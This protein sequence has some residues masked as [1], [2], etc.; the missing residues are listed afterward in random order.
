[1]GSKKHLCRV[2][3]LVGLQFA[4]WTE[5]AFSATITTFNDIQ[6]WVGTGEN[7]AA[8]VVDWDDSTATDESLIWGYRWTGTAT[9]SDMLQAVLAADDR[10][11]AKLDTSSTLAFG[12]GYDLNNDNQFAISDGSTFDAAGI[13]T[14]GPP[15]PP[16]APGT[17]SPSDTADHY[18][19][20][21]YTGFWNYGMSTGSASPFDDGAWSA[22]NLG[23]AGRVLT[24]GD[25]DSWAFTPDTDPP[26]A[27]FAENPYAAESPFSADFDADFDADDDI[28]GADF[29]TW[30]RGFGITAGASLAQGDANGD[31]RVDQHDLPIWAT[32]FGSGF[33]FGTFGS[34]IGSSA[35]QSTAFVV[36]EPS[37]IAAAVWFIVLI[38]NR[39]ISTK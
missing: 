21:W 26:H 14:G 36:P 29:L 28:D 31:Q 30:Q 19:E 39:D 22:S 20:G 38:Y 9:G 37:C 16:F 33:G 18:A 4:C 25:W 8:L 1:M 27:A 7:R 5:A 23:M 13:T 32:A 3:L 11:Y 10:L 12:F 2:A 35:L 6:F 17:A 34:E 15:D 24:D